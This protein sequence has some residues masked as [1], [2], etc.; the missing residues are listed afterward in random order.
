MI[1]FFNIEKLEAKTNNDPEYLVEVL[2]KAWLGRT[3]PKNAREKYKPI[4]TVVP[5]PSFLLN[6][7][8]L[9]LDRTTQIVH[10]AH[11]IRLAARRDYLLYKLQQQKYL[12]LIL[13]PDL[14]TGIIKQNPLLIISNNKLLFKY[15]ENNGTLIQTNQRQ[16]TKSIGRI[17]RVQRR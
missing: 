9:F 16:S 1:F 7:Q 4:P 10:K 2:H 5:G 15:E 8:E 3:I 6:P 14:N 13:Y 12:D 11:Y 17:L